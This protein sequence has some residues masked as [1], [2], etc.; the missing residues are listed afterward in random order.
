MLH[1]QNTKKAEIKKKRS[2]LPLAIAAVLVLALASLTGSY[3]YYQHW[4]NLE[5]EKAEMFVGQAWYREALEIYQ[6]LEVHPLLTPEHN[7][8]LYQR[9]NRI[10]EILEHSDKSPGK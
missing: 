4:L 5:F 8:I 10:Q 2:R 3:F 1:Y 7:K 6:E 9:I